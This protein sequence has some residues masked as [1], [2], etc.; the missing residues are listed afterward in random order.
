M[1]TITHIDVERLQPVKVPGVAIARRCR[2]AAGSAGAGKGSAAPPASRAAQAARRCRNGCRRRSEMFGSSGRAGSKRSGI[3]PARRIAVGG[4]EQQADLLALLEPDALDLDRLQRIAVEEVQRRVE[5]ERLL[6]DARQLNSSLE[7]SAAG[8]SS[9]SRIA[10]TALPIEC[11]V[12]S[13]PAFRSWIV[14]AISSS[15][16]SFSPA[17]SAA[18]RWLIRSSRGSLRRSRDIVAQERDEFLASPSTAASSTA[19]FRPGVYIA[20][21][22]CDQ[23]T[24][25]GP[26]STG[27]PRSSAM[28]VTGNRRA[29]GCDQVDRPL[30]LEAVDQL[31]ARAPRRAGGAFRSGARRRRG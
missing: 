7:K 22:R 5:A 31:V 26:S 1:R 17:A 4:G 2:R 11:T 27:T 28:T 12:A 20:T 13:W 10:F 19:R 29:I 18:I 8:D 9:D 30:L 3:V 15:S 16:E 21:I 6:A 23:S 25:R 24:S 14:P